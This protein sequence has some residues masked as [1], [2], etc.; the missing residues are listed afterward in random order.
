MAK[1]RTQICEAVRSRAMLSLTIVKSRCIV[2]IP[3][4]V[5]IDGPLVVW[6]RRPTH[7]FHA[8]RLSPC[9]S[10]ERTTM[11][12]AAAEAPLQYWRVDILF[13]W[14]IAGGHDLWTFQ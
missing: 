8:R 6:T 10:L 4:K 14:C 13:A 5:G 1:S 2:D 7:H 9:I 3:L 12:S 11:L